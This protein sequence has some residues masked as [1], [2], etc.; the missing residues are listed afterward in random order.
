MLGEN[1]IGKTTFI[2]MLA[3]LLKPD[4]VDMENPDSNVSYKLQRIN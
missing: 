3:S 1:G 4:L 2:P